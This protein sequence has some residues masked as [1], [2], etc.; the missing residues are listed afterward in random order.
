MR[1][2]REIVFRAG[3]RR[4]RSD[5]WSAPWASKSSATWRGPACPSTSRPPRTAHE[6]G[7]LERRTGRPTATP[8]P[9]RSRIPPRRCTICRPPRRALPA[10]RAGLLAID[11]RGRDTSGSWARP[12]AG[13]GSTASATGSSAGCTSCGNGSRA[14]F[15]LSDRKR[16]GSA[17]FRGCRPTW[18]GRSPRRSGPGRCA[19]AGWSWTTAASWTAFS[20]LPGA[21]PSGSASAQR[22]RPRARGRG[23]GPQGFGSRLNQS[24]YARRDRV[25]QSDGGLYFGAWE[26]GERRSSLAA[27]T[28]LV[29]NSGLS[30]SA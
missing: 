5:R 7:P 15:T 22:L 27:V 24:D 3:A 11:G 16:A 18:R 9:A 14:T 29:T 28:S 6:R 12:G 23:A 30:L 26:P 20:R 8:T 13:P 17:A 1:S 21:R 2:F 10:L 25:V 19:G 4:P